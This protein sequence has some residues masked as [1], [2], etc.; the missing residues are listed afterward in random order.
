MAVLSLAGRYVNWLGLLT[1]ALGVLLWQGLI[2][3]GVLDFAYL[4]PPSEI[5]SAVKEIWV[6]G[7]LGPNLRHTLEAALL[8]WV[9]G[10]VAGIVLGL[11]LGLFRTLWSYSMASFEALRALPVVAFV[12]VAVVIFGFSMKTE[13]VVSFYACLW[14]VMLNTYAGLRSLD[15]RLLEVGRVL[16]LRRSEVI[17]KV[18]LPATTAN[19]VVGLRLG[20]A[21]SFVLTLVAEMVGNPAG[22]GFALVQKGAALQPAQAF[23]YVVVIGVVGVVLN[24][25]LVGS[26]RLVLRNQLAAAGDLS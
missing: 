17:W 16:G 9:L 25:L 2:D 3:L 18:Q 21:V 15:A 7:E 19:V 5:A 20:L 8:G 14:P 13:I 1:L 11:L 22:L 24:A 6:A 4:P 26:A 12:P 23:A 10:A